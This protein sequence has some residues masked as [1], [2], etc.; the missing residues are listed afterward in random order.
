MQTSVEVIA[1]SIRWDCNLAW[2]SQYRV[3]VQDGGE[4]KYHDHPG[5][6]ITLKMRYP[7]WIHSEFMT[8]RDRARNAASSRAVS[9]K[10]SMTNCQFR[11]IDIP[12][13]QKG[14]QGGDT[15]DN[16]IK[17]RVYA[18]I[19]W[20]CRR[21]V[22]VLENWAKHGV[23][24]SIINRYLEPFSYIEVVCTATRWDHFLSL[25]DAPDAE[26]HFQQLAKMIRSAL[27]NSCPTATDYHLPFVKADEEINETLTRMQ[28][29][30][31]RCAAI[32]YLRPDVTIN[33]ELKVYE[34]LVTK[35]HSSPLEHPATSFGVDL[36]HRSGPMVGWNTLRSIVGQD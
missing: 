24:K 29:A 17:G 12:S 25:R 35:R 32:S 28:V 7:R 6:I 26:P 4:P 5:R 21:T 27:D 22:E 13:E 34:T 31:S 1:D 19:D 16:R 3:Q 30:A 33:Q 15:L 8:H 9:V 23:H 18:D 11:P 20:L 10:K 2:H 14:M 36:N